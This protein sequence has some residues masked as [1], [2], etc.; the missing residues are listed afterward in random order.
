MCVYVCV[1][2]VCMC[3]CLFVCVCVCLCVCTYI[4]VIYMPVYICV[5]VCVSLCGVHVCVSVCVCVCIGWGWDLCRVYSLV[6]FCLSFCDRVSQ[7]GWSLPAELAD[8]WAL[9]ITSPAPTLCRLSSE[10]TAAH[11]SCCLNFYVCSGDPNTLLIGSFSQ[12]PKLHLNC[13]I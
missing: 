7:W 9:R 11:C 6:T 4:C 5:Y 3:E 8:Q 12:P 1:W 10:S 13:K 2:C